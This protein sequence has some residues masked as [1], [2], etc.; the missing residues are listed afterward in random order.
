[1]IGD[2]L[3]LKPY[4][5]PPAEAIFDIIKNDLQTKSKRY[6][7]AIC[8]ESGCG[9]STLAIA[10]K[11]V[12]SDHHI[13]AFTIHMD[14]YF[15]LP[16]TDNHNQRLDDIN[17]VGPQEVDL[18]LLQ[19]HIDLVQTSIKDFYKPLIHYKENAK[20]TEYADLTEIDVVI[21]EGTY[22]GQL[23]NIDNIIF[24]D[25]T[26]L[27]TWEARMARGRD[28][29]DA[30]NEEVLKIEHLIIKRQKENANILVDG[31]YQVKI[32]DQKT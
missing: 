11:Q 25:R 21:I 27:D 26:Y 7:L 24:I 2:K 4:H 19:E 29:A 12:M 13:K 1:M 23:K 18:A 14:D 30:F 15:F 3:I 10:V 9:K 22:V 31:N 20:R 28:I 6:V 16:P 17:H 8:G 32:N 5:L